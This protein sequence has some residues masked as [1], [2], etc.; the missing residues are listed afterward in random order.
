MSSK[1]S[2]PSDACFAHRITL[3][4]LDGLTQAENVGVVTRNCAAIGVDLLIAG[5][6]AAS[7]YLRSGVKNSMGTTFGLNVRHV[8]DLQS[9]LQELRTH[10]GTL[11]Q[12]MR[13][14]LKIV[15]RGIPW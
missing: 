1:E 13:T 5:E 15:S 9:T 12:P 2:R 8:S 11:V 7:P 14:F 4:A 10:F 6:R 3:F